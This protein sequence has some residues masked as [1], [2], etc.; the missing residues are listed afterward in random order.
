M[1]FQGRNQ[2]PGV[3]NL[4]HLLCSDPSNSRQDENLSVGDQEQLQICHET[5][6]LSHMDSF[7]PVFSSVAPLA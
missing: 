4:T 7:L 1:I 5:K 6:G 3:G 2:L